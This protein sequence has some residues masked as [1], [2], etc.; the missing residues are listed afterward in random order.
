MDVSTLALSKVHPKWLELF[1]GEFK[2]AAHILEGKS[3]FQPALENVFR[4]FEISPDQVKVVVVGQD[5]YPTS[6]DAIGLAFAVSRDEKLPKSLQNLFKEL[7]SDL[8]VIRTSGDLGIWQEQGVLLLN[9]ILTTP[10]GQPLGHANIG[11]EEFTE[12]IIGYL[13]QTG[14]VALLMG[15][16]AQ[17]MGK[18]F[19]KKIETAH[20]SPLSAYRGFF[21]SKPF[22][23]IN[24]LLEH[25]ISW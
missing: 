22:S 15:N 14:A 13:G 24:Q 18:Y 12:K 10:T 19:D 16:K 21:G 5:P 20:P 9:R 6:G 25:P 8:G 2:S 3:N 4:A 11:W 23:R 17:E 7:Q 1:P